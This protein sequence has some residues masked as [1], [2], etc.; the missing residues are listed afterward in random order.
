ME[1]RARTYNVECTVASQEY[2]LYTCPDNCRA[3]MV[4]LYVTNASGTTATVNVEFDRADTSHVHILGSKN[5]A[6]GD[7]IQ[8]SGSYIV[9]EPG[10][11]MHVTVTGTATPHVDVM[12]TVEE[13]FLPNKIQ[14]L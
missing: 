14:Y 7:F 2:T 1:F 10:D 4:L 13:Y 12:C 9:L 5:M 6:N 11:I 3:Q 8:W